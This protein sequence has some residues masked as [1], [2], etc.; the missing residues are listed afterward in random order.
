MCVKALLLVACLLVWTAVFSRTAAN[1]LGEVPAG[2]FRSPE[3][4]R[5]FSAEAGVKPLNNLVF[6]LLNIRSPGSSKHNF[7]N[8]RDGWVYIRISRKVDDRPAAVI[9]ADKQLTL[10]M[11]D[12]HFEVMRYVTAGE[13]SVAIAR[14]SG[15]I[16]RLEVR[17]I[18]ELFHAT[19]GGNPHVPE[20]GVYTWDFLRR[21]CLDHCN[22]II[23]SNSLSPDGKSTQEAEIKQ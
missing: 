6:E 18:G 9:L 10:K 17:A 20:I 23:G 14:G 19:Y 1:E 13:H 2:G 7:R 21:D 3:G 5:R 12:D 11:V 22:S 15:P 4:D 8:L 16:N